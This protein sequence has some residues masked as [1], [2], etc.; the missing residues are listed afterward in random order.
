[1]TAEQQLAELHKWWSAY[2]RWVG[3]YLG[4]QLRSTAGATAWNGYRSTYLHDGVGIHDYEFV[5][6]AE[7]AAV[8]PG[9]CQCFKLGV[10]RGRICHVDVVG[11][12]TTMALSREY[13]SVVEWDGESD[14]PGVS[15]WL[16]NGWGVIADVT[17]S[18]GGGRYPYRDD[19]GVYYPRGPMRTHLVGPELRSAFDAGIVSSVG[20]CVVYRMAP[21]LRAYGRAMLRGIAD[22]R[23]QGVRGLVAS[24][25]LTTHTL[26]GRWAQRSR[27]WIRCTCI[28]PRRK[29][30]SW[31]APD[32]GPYHDCRNG[33][34]VTW[35]SSPPGETGR[36]MLTRWRSIGGLVEYATCERDSPDTSPAVLAYLASYCRVRLQEIIDAVG[37][38]NMVYCDTDGIY[39]TEDGFGKLCEADMIGDGSPGTLR[40]VGT[41][42]GVVVYGAKQIAKG[43]GTWTHAGVPD[44][45]EVNGDTAQWDTCRG[46][47][48]S[49]RMGEAPRGQL[50]LRR[51]R[52][53]VSYRHGEIQPDGRVTPITVLRAHDG[54]RP[55]LN[56]REGE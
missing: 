6:S 37:E 25:K 46:M 19:T 45:A 55:T 32:P 20:H 8:T 2:R 21:I 5:R 29:W 42:D 40:V 31:F 10:V 35:L 15:E 49:L 14:A 24:V 51:R 52:I 27:R 38:R 11:A 36:R 53:S 26:W 34:G 56:S 50:T 13:P 47:L 9:R 44:D 1:M 54:S 4:G 41:Y 3:K 39:C 22:A 48:D 43:D 12:Y 7:R 33:D 28:P 16:S 17:L 30:D 18:D 23:S